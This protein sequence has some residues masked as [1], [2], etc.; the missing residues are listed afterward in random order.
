MKVKDLIKL[1]EK[2]NQEANIYVSCQGYTNLCD[3]DTETRLCKIN[4]DNYVLIDN[5]WLE[6]GISL[7]QIED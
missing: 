1:L 6:V 2:Q 7:E 4:K 3:D 5:C